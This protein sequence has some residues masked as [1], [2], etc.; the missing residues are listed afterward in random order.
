VV[1]ATAISGKLEALGETSIVPR[2]SRHLSKI[3][4]HLAHLTP[5]ERQQLRV[6]LDEA[7]NLPEVR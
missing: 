1:P 3:L 7:T 6:K 4:G 2:Q 5:A